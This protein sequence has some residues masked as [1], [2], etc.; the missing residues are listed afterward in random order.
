[1]AQQFG[2]MDRIEDY[3]ILRSARRLIT[4]VAGATGRHLLFG[5]AIDSCRNWADPSKNADVVGVPVEAASYLGLTGGSAY[6]NLNVDETLAG[7]YVFAGSIFTDPDDALTV[8]M[9]NYSGGTGLGGATLSTAKNG[10]ADC[11]NASAYFYSS[12][13]SAYKFESVRLNANVAQAACIIMDFDNSGVRLYNMT[14]GEGVGVV[15]ASGYV[16]APVSPNKLRLGVGYGGTYPGLS[17]PTVTE[18]YP[19]VL[20]ADQRAKVY[21]HVKGLAAAL[22]RTV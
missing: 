14:T 9:G 2:R 20:T 22:G 13:A 8:A 15:A 4:P 10:A 19:F 7:T 1:M 5:S 16:R 6:L 11:Y 17:R 21:A 18:A 3:S 12:A